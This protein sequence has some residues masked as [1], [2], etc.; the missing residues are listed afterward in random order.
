MLGFGEAG[1]TIV[2]QNIGVF[3]DVDP[4]VS[5]K[6]IMAIYGFCDIRQFTGSTEALQEKVMVFVNNI[7]RI[8]HSTT[9][10]FLGAPN[11]NIGDAFLLVWRIPDSELFHDFRGNLTMAADSF[12]VNNV[13]DAALIS[14]LKTLCKLTREKSIRAY[15][16]NEHLMQR[17]GGKYSLKLGFGLHVG[18]SFEG[19]L[20]SPYKIDATYLS[21]HV[22]FSS[23]LEGLTKDY[24]V[25]VLLS[26]K[27]YEILSEESQRRCRLID[28]LQFGGSIEEHELY[29]VNVELGKLTPQDEISQLTNK[30]LYAMT[31]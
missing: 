14:V 21:S 19:A 16:H 23:T 22:N 12:I 6:K 29:T 17:F 30:D 26:G 24:G 20:G 28:K 15:R 7:A 13:A 10:E 9:S 3:G 18:Y 4:M 8:V 2:A 11:K 5:G 31:A 1:S 25:L 27:F